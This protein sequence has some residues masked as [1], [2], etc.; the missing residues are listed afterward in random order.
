LTSDPD[1]VSAREHGRVLA[2]T[3]GFS[4]AD[5]ASVE[6]TIAELAINMLTYARSGEIR[7]DVVVDGDTTGIR[8]VARDWGFAGESLELSHVQRLA[9]DF[10]IRRRAGRGTVVTLTKWLRSTSAAA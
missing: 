1:V 7:L 9:D 10:E 2:T 6:A 4:A 3:L 5:Q 8:V